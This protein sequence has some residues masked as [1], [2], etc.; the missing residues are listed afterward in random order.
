[1]RQVINWLVFTF[2]SFLL[3][4]GNAALAQ[5]NQIFDPVKW[6]YSSKALGNN[7]FE[8]SF[9]AEIEDH[10]HIYSQHGSLDEG[11]I[12]TAF[13]FKKSDDY[14][15]IGETS[16]PKGV[17]KFE[18]M[19][20]I[21]VTYFDHKAVFKQKVHLK[22]KEAAITGE[23]IYMVCNDERCLPPDYIDFEFKLKGEEVKVEKASTEKVESNVTLIGA[24]TAGLGENEIYTPVTW[25]QEA[26]KVGENEYEIIFSAK[27]DEG[28]HLY[29]AYLP[30]DDG[31]I[32]TA[33]EFEKQEGV[34]LDGKILENGDLHKEYDPNFQMDLTYF[35]NEVSFIQKVVT[36]ANAKNVK[37]EI[38]FMACNS[39]RCIPPDY[40]PFDL[41]L[42]EAKEGKPTKIMSNDGGHS[43]DDGKE[44]KHE[45]AAAA[46]S[47]SSNSVTDKSV[48]TIFIL[49]FLSGL[50]ALLTPCVFPMIPMTVSFFTKQSKSKAEGIKNAIIYGISIIA[51]YVLLGTVVTAVFG[52]EILSNLATDPIFNF[53]FFLLLIVFA[54]SFL[55]AFE[56][57]LPSSWINKADSQADKGG[58]IGIFFMALVLALVSFSCTGPIVGTLIVEAASKGGATPI[59]G[60]F[61]FSLAIALPFGLFAAFPGWM[62]SMP[63]SGGWLN[64]VKVVLGFLEL[65]L[66][67]KFLSN[68][69]LVL[70]LHFLEREVFI[71]LWVI[72]FGLL[73]LYLLGKLR[74]PHDSPM[75][76][77]SVSRLF[78]AIVTGAFTV[79][80]IPGMWGAPLKIISA[81]PP[82][83]HY[84]ESPAGVGGGGS[85]H[86][87]H[88]DNPDRH[89]GPQGILV[90]HDY[91]KG[92]AYAK[93]K[94]MPVMI[95]FTG[96]A[97]VNCRKMEESV[98]S[99]PEIKEMLA[100][101]V[102]VISLY[103][104]ERTELPKEEQKEVTYPDGKKR[105]LRNVGNKWAYKQITEYKA[106]SQPLYVIQD[107]NGKDLTSTANYQDHGSVP[108]F[109]KWLK[110]GIKKS[111]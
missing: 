71:A 108:V 101:D 27:V 86:V 67:F 97:C 20:G 60:M 53:V 3:L 28:W 110:D 103:V 17:T 64:S 111:K 26:V 39:E 61:G 46:T 83:L 36:E 62:N 23:L 80:M 29:S 77:V 47:N 93:E 82:P 92:L 21:D 2:F 16:E 38:I 19:F 1:M 15:L 94:K 85:G 79:Y 14:E 87:S 42:A 7:D 63:K 5:D 10:W 45:E 34:K 72:I 41:N 73:T 99:D 68:A 25:K 106:N 78:L 33:F 98:W 105:K 8:L 90:F 51:I 31:P 84:S 32:A 65:A 89:V 48:L 58:I 76:S 55:G 91:D 59:I 50:A 43:S 4:G 30:S 49:S 44:E 88:S 69:D 24:P 75:E 102:V 81:F 54:A 40:I 66:A 70:Q 22:K 12:P 18:E 74:L 56:I 37:G 35:E 11:P 9:I 13:E 52:A 96:H 6:K 100:N 107:Y 104:D 109:K 57:T 95:D